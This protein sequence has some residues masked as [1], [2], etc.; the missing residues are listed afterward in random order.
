MQVEKV[1]LAACWILTGWLSITIRVQ[2]FGSKD[3]GTE[4]LKGRSKS[5]SAS[6]C[7]VLMEYIPGDG[8]VDMAWRMFRARQPQ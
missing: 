1:P 8:E 2:G 5:T 3:T 7:E 6:S 4:R